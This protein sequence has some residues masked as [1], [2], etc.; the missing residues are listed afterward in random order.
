MSKMDPPPE[1][2]PEEMDDLVSSTEGFSGSDLAV[3]ISDAIMVPV[4][5]PPS[6]PAPAPAHG[7]GPRPL[8]TR[9]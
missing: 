7:A 1:V 5:P 4:V 8:C 3:W 6:A 9:L 2:L